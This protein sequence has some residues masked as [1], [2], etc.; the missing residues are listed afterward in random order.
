MI[1]NRYNPKFIDQSNC[2][3]AST[4]RVILYSVPPCKGDPYGI[5]DKHMSFDQV[6]FYKLQFTPKNPYNSSTIFLAHSSREE[7][8]KIKRT[9]CLG[10]I[11][12]NTSDLNYVPHSLVCPH[13]FLSS[14]VTIA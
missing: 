6:V 4:Y 3:N 9:S 8:Q 1:S 10:L 5:V 14:K 7:K 11:K 12:N 13:D 2:C